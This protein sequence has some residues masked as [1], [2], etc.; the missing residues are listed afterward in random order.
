VLR[1]RR[2]G[3]GDSEAMTDE[4]QARLAELVRRAEREQ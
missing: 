3:G 4:E 1:G 2:T